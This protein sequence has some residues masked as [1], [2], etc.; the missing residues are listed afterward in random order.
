MAEGLA[1]TACHRDYEGP[2]FMKAENMAKETSTSKSMVE[3]IQEIEESETL[4][5][6]VREDDEQKFS[7]GL[8]Q[9]GLDE[10]TR[11]VAQW[12]VTPEELEEKTAEVI[13]ASGKLPLVTPVSFGKASH[14]SLAAYFAGAAQHPPKQVKFDFFYMHAINSNLFLSEF[15]SP[16]STY[17]ST[18]A[19]CRLVEWKGRLDL[20]IYKG[21]GSPKLLVTEITGYQPRGG[22]GSWEDVFHRACNVT[23]DGHCSKFIRSLANGE[24]VCARY[25]AKDTFK[26]K[27]GMW[28]KLAHMGMST[29]SDAVYPSRTS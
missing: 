12:K 8:L 25:E 15:C 9:R 6:F 5:R 16:S 26:I 10:I 27:G 23:D 4:K 1:Q 20:A 14:S 11:V 3:L 24:K 13:N 29:R 7:Q 19:K 18:A 22:L 17:L 2:F 21:F 28:L